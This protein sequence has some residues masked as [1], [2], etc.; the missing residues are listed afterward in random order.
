MTRTSLAV[1]ALAAVL[2]GCANLPPSATQASLPSGIQHTGQAGMTG[3]SAAPPSG[4]GAI[5]TTRP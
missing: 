1:L 5:V 4:A 3:G 2:A